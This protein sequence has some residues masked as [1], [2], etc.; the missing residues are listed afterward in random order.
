MENVPKTWALLSNG[1]KI[2][3]PV[4]NY[5]ILS[6]KGLVLPSMGTDHTPPMSAIDPRDP[7]INFQFHI[8]DM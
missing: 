4:K 6:T 7:V 2:F 8:C 3:L 1:G 5:S